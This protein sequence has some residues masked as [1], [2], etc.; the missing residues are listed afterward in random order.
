MNKAPFRYVRHYGGSLHEAPFR[1]V[2]RYAPG[3]DAQGAVQVGKPLGGSIHRVP[4]RY[5]AIT[6]GRQVK[7]D[8]LVAT[9][10]SFAQS[11]CF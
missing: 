9:N 3:F 2:G 11:C 4:F 6:G 10:E 7:S 5:E 1:C 8:G